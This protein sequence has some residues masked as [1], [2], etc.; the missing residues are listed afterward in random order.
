MT[1]GFRRQLWSSVPV[2]PDK[3]QNVYH[4]SVNGHLVLSSR[5]NQSHL[6]C[7]SEDLAEKF[8]FL[9]YSGRCTLYFFE[10]NFVEQ[11][12]G[13][14]NKC[15]II[16]CT[17]LTSTSMGCTHIALWIYGEKICFACFIKRNLRGEKSKNTWNVW[18]LFQFKIIPKQPL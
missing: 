14:W 4:P 10:H 11:P 5:A 9:C 13:I 7:N 6:E 2:P 3:T 16:F 12:A 1:R 18:K 8:L 17:L 15:F